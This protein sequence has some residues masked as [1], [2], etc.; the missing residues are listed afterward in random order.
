MSNAANP[1]QRPSEDFDEA[2]KMP[3]DRFLEWYHAREAW[4][5]MHGGAAMPKDLKE[6]YKRLTESR[7]AA[8]AAG[9]GKTPTA[10]ETFSAIKHRREKTAYYRAHRAAILGSQP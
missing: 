8:M 1:P 3:D 9:E 6:R 7:A 4:V 10:F 2:R 5:K